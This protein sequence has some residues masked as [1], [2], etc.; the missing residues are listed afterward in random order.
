MKI[1]ANRTRVISF[2]RKTNALTFIYVIC[3][4][5]ILRTDCVKTLVSFL[6]PKF[7]FINM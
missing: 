4:S 3:N 6:T 2:S 7:T 1:N 5:D